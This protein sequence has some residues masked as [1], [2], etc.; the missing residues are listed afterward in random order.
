MSLSGELRRI[1]GPA[2][3]TQW[4]RDATE[5]FD[6]RKGGFISVDSFCEIVRQFLVQRLTKILEERNAE[7]IARSSAVPRNHA[8]VGRAQNTGGHTGAVVA[9]TSESLDVVIWPPYNFT[10]LT[11][12]MPGKSRVFRSQ[13]ATADEKT[14]KDTTRRAQ[15]HGDQTHN[16]QQLVRRELRGQTH[17]DQT[18]NQQQL[19]RAF[20]QHQTQLHSDPASNAQ[21]VP[22]SN[23]SI[24]RGTK[25]PVKVHEWY[26]FLDV[27][28]QG[29]FGKVTMVQDRRSGVFKACKSIALKNK[30]QTNLVK[31]EINVMKLLAGQD[32]ILVLHEVHYEARDSTRDHQHSTSS[33]KKGP[34]M[35]YLILELC[36][37]GCLFDRLLYHTNALRRPMSERQAKLY[38]RQIL[39]ALAYCH[40]LGILHRDVK[41]DNI[42]FETRKSDAVLKLIDF[43][44]SDFLANIRASAKVVRV[45]PNEMKNSSTTSSTT[46]TPV[47]G[48]RKNKASLSAGAAGAG[49]GNDTPGANGNKV[50]VQGHDDRGR[51]GGHKEVVPYQLQRR[52][53]PSAS[54]QDQ[55]QH[56][57]DAKTRASSASP[58]N[59]SLHIKGGSPVAAAAQERTSRHINRNTACSPV[60]SS[61]TPRQAQGT[62]QNGAAAGGRPA[63]EGGAT[64]GGALIHQATATAAA[65]PNPPVLQPAQVQTAQPSPIVPTNQPARPSPIVPSNQPAQPSPVVQQKDPSSQYFIDSKDGSA[66]MRIAAKAGTPHYMSPEMHEKAWYDF[67]ADLFACGVILYH[68]LSNAHPFFTPRKDKANSARARIC[69]C[70]PSYAE[71]AW[72]T[73]SDEALYFTRALLKKDPKERLS[74]KDALAHEWLTTDAGTRTSS[75]GTRASTS[76]GATRGRGGKRG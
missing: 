16:Q 39:S 62:R 42:L 15:T 41:P 36:N 70:R 11:I 38:I 75:G 31:T 50:A 69:V 13:H 3:S 65:Q 19:E 40:S 1:V 20:H 14:S 72:S 45:R 37:G 5:N 32:N 48:T 25:E 12:F 47:V 44:L 26:S 52:E 34:N 2:P 55:G 4:C 49:G 46:A 8:P 57:D 54:G 60:S 21:V 66:W 58:K 6:A 67:K 17:G 35:V 68:M 29:A 24:Y 76:S 61:N 33:S 53:E 73:L 23:I 74:A 9:E 18:H 59:N 64:A 27:K 28:G 71:T 51:A 7:M 63:Q 43:G 10:P 22:K 56:Q 30:S